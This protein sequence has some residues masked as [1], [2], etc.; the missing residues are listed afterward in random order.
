MRARRIAT[1]VVKWSQLRRRGV[2]AR[3]AGHAAAI[4]QT[5][6][7]LHLELED[8]GKKRTPRVSWLSSTIRPA[9]RAQ[10]LTREAHIPHCTTNPYRKS[11][12]TAHCRPHCTWIAHMDGHTPH[13]HTLLG[14]S[15]SS[16]LWAVPISLFLSLHLFNFFWQVSHFRMWSSAPFALDLSSC[17]RRMSAG[18]D[19]RASGNERDGLSTRHSLSFTRAPHC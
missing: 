16:A 12:H 4:Q 17:C 2:L 9:L 1:H 11:T 7:L 8:R 14:S 19:P 6:D 18:A 13:R 15:L 3:R 5:W 10:P